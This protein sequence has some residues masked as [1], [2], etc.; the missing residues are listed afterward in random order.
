MTDR[1]EL[2]AALA[3]IQP[4]AAPD[5]RVSVP[6]LVRAWLERGPAVFE[7][8]DRLSL[9]ALCRQIDVRKRVSAGYGA[10]FTRL[11]PEVPADAAV[12]SG[13]VAVLLANAA[14]VGDPAARVDGAVDDGWGLKCT[15]SAFK[16]LDLRDDAPHAGELRVWAMDVLDRH[17]SGVDER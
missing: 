5:A 16:A 4:G 8:D 17:A 11:D 7:G 1:S 6:A 15:N 12:V 9:E 14:R 3:A 13:L 10:G 2:F